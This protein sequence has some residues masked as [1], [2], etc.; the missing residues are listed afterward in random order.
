MIHRHHSS[1]IT[2]TTSS[3]KDA[4]TT[5]D[6][7]D[8]DTSADYDNATVEDATVEASQPAPLPS[9]LKTTE[10]NKKNTSRRVSVGLPVYYDYFSR[11]NN[12]D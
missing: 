5:T 4:T 2:P 3:K 10:S 9:I 1:D 8:E 7:N 11:Y 6:A 12:Q